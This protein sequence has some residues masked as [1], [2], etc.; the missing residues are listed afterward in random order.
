[1][2]TFWERSGYIIIF[3]GEGVDFFPRHVDD[4]ERACFAEDFFGLQKVSSA[5]IQCSEKTCSEKQ[6]KAAKRQQP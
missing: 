6:N 3:H 4:G 5:Y 1:M 2:G